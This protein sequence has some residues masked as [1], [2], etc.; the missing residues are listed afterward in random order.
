M[1]NE[2]AIAETITALEQASSGYARVV[3]AGN[4][5]REATGKGLADLRE[6]VMRMYG[7]RNRVAAI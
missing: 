3:G 2:L 6:Q 5:A 4:N 1:I 7:R